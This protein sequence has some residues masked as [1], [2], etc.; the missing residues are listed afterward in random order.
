MMEHGL[1]KLREKYL[2]VL[3]Y[4]LYFHMIQ[5]KRNI[6]IKQF[7]VGV[8]STFKDELLDEIVAGIIDKNETPEETAKRECFEETGCIVKKII[9][10][11]NIF[12]LQD[13]QSHFT[14]FF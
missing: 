10:I 4:Q 7:R 13:H 5:K 1:I 11:Q 2:K 12:Q 6:L 3:E 8:L 9:P 14:M